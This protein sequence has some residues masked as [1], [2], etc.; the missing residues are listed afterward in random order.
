[1][2]LEVRCIDNADS[3]SADRDISKHLKVKQ[4]LAIETGV[5]MAPAQNE[6]SLRRNLV[7]FS[8]EKQIDPLKSRNVRRQVAKIRADLTMD[9]LD[10]F[11]IDDFVGSLVRFAESKWL[12]SLIVEHNNEDSHFHYN[13]FQPFVNGRDLNSQNDINYINF[14][15]IW[16]FCNFLC[17]IGAGWLLQV[18]GDATD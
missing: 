10:N 5:R 17:N 14:S 6:G 4:L 13:L 8:P 18:N 3:H 15:T 16:H 11:E 2:S 1:M 12:D 9:Q 7:N